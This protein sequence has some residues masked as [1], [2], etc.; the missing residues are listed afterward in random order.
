MII[1]LGGPGFDITQNDT[2][3]AVT[4]TSP[5]ADTTIEVGDSIDF[6]GSVANG[7]EPFT[8]SWNFGGGAVSSDQED[9]E[10]VTFSTAGTYTV[11]FTVT[12]VD[13]DTDSDTVVITVNAPAG[14]GDGGGGGGGGGCFIDSMR[15]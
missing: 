9:P 13:N 4:I 10:S 11:T 12:D 2:E 6:Q 3:P 1:D 7:N 5:S 8:Y 14:G 15:Y